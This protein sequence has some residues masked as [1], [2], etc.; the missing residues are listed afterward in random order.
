MPV[1]SFTFY[2]LQRLGASIIVV[3][4]NLRTYLS[5]I[6]YCVLYIVVY[7][8]NDNWTFLKCFARIG[9]NRLRIQISFESRWINIEQVSMTREVG[10]QEVL[11]GRVRLLKIATK[12]ARPKNLPPQR[13]IECRC[14]GD[15][16]RLDATW[17]AWQRLENEPKWLPEPRHEKKKKVN[18]RREAESADAQGGTLGT[19]WSEISQIPSRV[20]GRQTTMAGGIRQQWQQMQSI[21]IDGT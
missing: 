20:A 18:P 8:S 3:K 12:S 4:L 5:Q 6:F 16:M 21:R 19:G 7:V 17:C 2:R 14:S 13:A 10:E 1:P 15:E 9:H 11:Q